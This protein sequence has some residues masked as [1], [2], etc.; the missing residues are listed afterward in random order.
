MDKLFIS[1]AFPALSILLNLTVSLIYLLLFLLNFCFFIDLLCTNYTTYRQLIV[2]IIYRK[3]CNFD[4]TT[5]LYLQKTLSYFNSLSLNWI[6]H[7][8][9]V[10]TFVL[11]M[12]NRIG[13]IFPSPSTPCSLPFGTTRSPQPPTSSF[14]LPGGSCTCTR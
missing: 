6:L 7:Q 8:L 12:S 9:F 3:K 2:T 1:R 5:E 10:H 13:E 4:H 14:P 11:S